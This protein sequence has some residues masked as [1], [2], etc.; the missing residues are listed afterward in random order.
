MESVCATPFPESSL[1]YAS[2]EILPQMLSTAFPSKKNC[3]G[4]VFE[5]DTMIKVLILSGK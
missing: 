5:V 3:S 4:D 1:W 2:D